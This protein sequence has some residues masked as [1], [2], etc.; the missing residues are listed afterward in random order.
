MTLITVGQWTTI[1]KSQ[2]SSPSW[3]DA[4]IAD[5]N[6]KQTVLS[7]NTVIKGSLVADSINTSNGSIE[8]RLTRIEERLVIFQPS[9][10][11][12]SRWDTLR[13]LRKQYLELEKDILE[14]EEIIRILKNS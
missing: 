8:Q 3:S 12:E 4:I 9:L 6:T 7:G 1:N 13:E 14:Q 10:E 2:H 5:P 11:L